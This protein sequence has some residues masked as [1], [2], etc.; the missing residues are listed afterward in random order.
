MQFRKGQ[1]YP[2]E[3]VTADLVIGKSYNLGTGKYEDTKR[4]A[5]R[6]SSKGIHLHPVKEV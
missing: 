4:F 2:I 3:Y 5:I 6:Y 1:Q